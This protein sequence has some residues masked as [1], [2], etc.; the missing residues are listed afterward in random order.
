[1]ASVNQPFQSGVMIFRQRS[2]RGQ[3]GWYL[4]RVT[5]P[6]GTICK[7]IPQTPRAHA[8]SK[9]LPKSTILPTHLGTIW[10]IF[11]GLIQFSK[12]GMQ[13]SIIYTNY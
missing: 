2:R 8:K 5:P 7:H 4:N 10:F 13:N 12:N 3:G 11:Q 1:M 9:A 6:A